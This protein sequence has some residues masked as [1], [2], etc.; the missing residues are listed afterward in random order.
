VQRYKE[1]A[2]MGRI[3]GFEGRME[4]RSRVLKRQEEAEETAG[5]TFWG[6]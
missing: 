6:G 3:C 5:S 2:V 4:R 1:I